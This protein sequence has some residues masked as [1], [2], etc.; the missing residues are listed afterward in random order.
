[1]SGTYTY[2]CRNL[3][4]KAERAFI[5]ASILLGNYGNTGKKTPFFTLQ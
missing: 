1:M 4:G 3:E 2:L 5:K